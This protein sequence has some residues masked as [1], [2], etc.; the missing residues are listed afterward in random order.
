V[1]CRDPLLGNDRETNN[2][3]KTYVARQQATIVLQQERCF[4][5]SPCR[6]RS[7]TIGVMSELWDIRQP[8]RNSAEDIV[9]ICY[10][11]TTSEDIE[12]FMCAAVTVIFRECKPVRLLYLLVVT[13]RVCKWSISR[14][15]N[16]NRVCSQ[17][18]TSL[19]SFFLPVM[20]LTSIIPFLPL[21][22]FHFIHYSI[23]CCETS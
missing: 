18:N 10:Q 7:R 20:F 11:E 14:V 17:P 19:Y 4:L 12:E 2:N 9:R 3:K 8:V 1:T 23:K 15:T 13:S 21:M 5:C 16:P 6:D 22:S